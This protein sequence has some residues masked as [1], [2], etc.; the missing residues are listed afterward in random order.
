MKT[1]LTAILTFTYFFSFSQT[2]ADL[3]L[4]K[5]MQVEGIASKSF[6]AD[7]IIVT[8]SSNNNEYEAAAYMEALYA[9]AAAAEYDEDG[10][11][12]D[13]EKNKKDK[14]ISQLSP[15]KINYEQEKV[16]LISTLGISSNII[17]N[18]I[19]IP[20]QNCEFKLCFKNEKSYLD[21]KRKFEDYFSSD[22]YNAT[23]KI[24]KGTKFLLSANAQKLSEQAVLKMA[25]DNAKMKAEFI[26]KNLNVKLGSVIAFKE[27][28]SNSSSSSS[29][30]G[31]YYNMLLQGAY[32]YD[33]GTKGQSSISIEK[34][35]T[36]Y[37]KILE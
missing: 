20:D 7:S 29:P 5:N 12:K 10:E 17:E 33:M 19:C 25:I 2:A 21:F 22:K 3:S 11:E 32:D 37:Y 4:G 36:V 34:T 8:I 13:K 23:W 35:I 18:S 15:E 1:L 26:S 14:E 24:A 6:E 30:L 16:K 9:A 31:D 27:S 28:S